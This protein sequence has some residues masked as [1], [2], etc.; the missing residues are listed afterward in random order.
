[1]A[2]LTDSTAPS[3]K[4]SSANLLVLARKEEVMNTSLTP[5]PTNTLAAQRPRLLRM[6][7]C[8]HRTGLKKSTLYA[9]IQKGQF[10]AP[11]Q[12]PG[13]RASVWVEAKVDAWVTD[14]CARHGQ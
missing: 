6:H 1:V 7:E 11:I 5:N 8:E 13:V 3:L 14:V 10:P 2:H 12:V 9:L 4:K